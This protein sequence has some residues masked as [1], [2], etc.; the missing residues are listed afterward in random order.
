MTLHPTDADL[1]AEFGRYE[2]LRVLG[3]GG[4]GRVYEAELHG[5]AGFRKRVALKVIKGEGA[6]LAREAR[7]GALLKHP[8]IVETYDLGEV[9]GSPYIA[10]EL[11]QGTSVEALLDRGPL[12]ARAAL[13]VVQQACNGLAN[14]HALQIDDRP[15]GLVH[16]D[17]KPANLLV[18]R[19]GLVKVADFGIARAHGID[20]GREVR[21]TPAYMAPE[22][23][24]GDPVDARA[25]LFAIGAVL[26]EVLS[27]RRAFPEANRAAVDIEARLADPT[28]LS[29][30][31]DAMPDAVPV[32][33]RC[34]R[35]R[36]DDRF[37]SMAELAATVAELA[38]RA[39]GASLGG[40]LDDVLGGGARASR[41]RAI[42]TSTA[43][44][45][46]TGTS[47][48][49]EL[50]PAGPTNLPTET[51]P[52]VGRRSEL[53]RLSEAFGRS[54]LVTLR[55]APGVGKSRLALH[56]AT[57][58]SAPGGVWLC[59]VDWTATLPELLWAIGSA[60]AVPLGEL[61]A[62]QAAARLGRALGARGRTM[63]ILDG[64]DRCMA[65]VPQL[66][67]DWRQA[68]PDLRVLVTGR[69][70][71]GVDGEFVF[72][73]GSMSRGD[74]TRLL[75]V[76]SASG[77]AT[78]AG[79]LGELARR[80][81]GAPQAVEMASAALRTTPADTLIAELDDIRVDGASRETALQ[82][83]LN[84]AWKRLDEWER[85]ALA[86]LSVFRAGFFL[87]AAEEVLDLEDYPDAP[88]EIDALETLVEHAAIATRPVS[89]TPRFRMS[90]TLE[91]LA[92]TNREIAPV[93][94]RHIVAFSKLAQE[95]ADVSGRDAAQKHRA[96]GVEVPNLLAALE[97]ATGKDAAQIAATAL[98]HL[99]PTAPMEMVDAVIERARAATD[100]GS[101]PRLDVELAAAMW[102]PDADRID[103]ALALSRTLNKR[104]REA[105]LLE[106]AAD[107]DRAL[108]DAEAAHAR[109]TEAVA[110][111]K[112]NRDRPAEA[113]A[114]AALAMLAHAAGE[115]EQ[116]R[117]TLEGA[118]PV[119]RAT[120][121]RVLEGRVLVDLATVDKQLGRPD[122]ARRHLDAAA[123][124][125]D[126]VGD[127]RALMR[128]YEA[129]SELPRAESRYGAEAAGL[130]LSLGDI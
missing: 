73:I 107:L 125:F 85:A 71:L 126:E 104:K 120:N 26:Y 37:S 106:N 1:P 7:L 38:R 29:P 40:V 129:L 76:R 105:R 108:G 89:G 130:A 34:L 33:R 10:M 8:N 93:A 42:A 9:E 17:L 19:T 121:R 99:G 51:V 94:A 95:L 15:A 115:H 90:A 66:V 46:D 63:L 97:R 55:G 113:R 88:W 70:E 36:R 78:E 116:A 75:E 56:F 35:A 123:L 118:L 81:E 65:H 84:W 103:E 52:F 111:H 101:L 21:G 43:T 128:A 30:I 16:L 110:K 14:A 12:P 50:E 13:E 112:A 67:S 92:A 119:L 79:V 24:R 23:R 83:A 28:F 74:A 102:R 2:L 117:R 54:D 45:T 114:Q 11:V 32:V 3:E 41:V 87:E 48:T 5:P 57:D 44:P 47:D 82:N 62:E 100:A 122:E 53:T 69:S 59:E 58:Y 22:H 4:M 91:D 60:M 80:L 20:S 61:D 96:I 18:D 77:T 39:P 64:V 6:D 72:D 27:G 68:Q 49:F 86:Q 124:A 98:A 31:E 25:D 109:L 127:R